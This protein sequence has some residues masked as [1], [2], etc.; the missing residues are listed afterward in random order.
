VTLALKDSKV[1]LEQ[2][3]DQTATLSTKQ[4]DG[5]SMHWSGIVTEACQ[6]GCDEVYDFYQLVLEPRLVRLRSWRWSD[7]YLNARLDDMIVQL[8]KQID[9]AQPYVP[10]ADYDYR[11]IPADLASTKREFVCQFEESCLDFLM[12]QLEH[13]GVYFWFE[14]NKDQESIVF[15]NSAE[16]QPQEAISAV[17]YPKGRINA[18]AREIAITRLNRRIG[19]HPKSVTLHASPVHGNT[20]ISLTST[21]ATS[22]PVNSLGEHHGYDD[23]FEHLDGTSDTSGAVL[24]EWR[25]QELLCQS[26]RVEGESRTPGIRAGY[27]LASFEY[28]PSGPSSDYYIVL[29]SHEGYQTLETSEKHDEPPYRGRFVALPRWQE[30]AQNKNPLQFRPPRA[31]PVPQVA[32]MVNGFVDTGTEGSPKRY[33]QTDDKGR[34][35]IRFCFTRKQYNGTFNSAWVRLATPYTGGASS[36]DLKPAGM[37]FPLREGTEVLIAFINGNPDR[38]VIV[39]ALPNVEAPSIVNSGNASEHLVQTP[40]GN[41]LALRDAAATDGSTAT[42]SDPSIQLSSPTQNSELNL[43][44]SP[45]GD[46]ANDGFSLTTDNHGLL[47]AGNSMLIE[48]P[49]HLHI[50]AGGGAYGS[51]LGSVAN[52]PAGVTVSTSGGIV[53]SNFVGANIASTGGLAMSHFIGAKVDITEA[54]TFESNISAGTKFQLG[55]VKEFFA[56][57]TTTFGEHTFIFGDTTMTGANWTGTFADKRETTATSITASG[58]YLLSSPEIMFSAETT[59]FNMTPAS[60]ILESTGAVDITGAVAATLMGE[61][62]KVSTIDETASMAAAAGEVLI[63]GTGLASVFSAAEV[64]IQGTDVSI[65]GALVTI[66]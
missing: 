56:S 21:H 10:D 52:T 43:G 12:R 17:Y 53:V 49:G 20:T 1:S 55:P 66:A 63:R 64:V 22:V 36:K 58:T 29:I 2:L 33:A 41:V 37:H 14:Q 60:A 32:R 13:Y 11:I 3:L 44:R 34:Y 40:A 31:T 50:A 46:S 7:I 26:L 25:D 42:S 5:T 8:L 24:A 38:P 16:Q 23:Q 9:M 6:Q 62:V 48:V 18:D 27:P 35:K 47:H 65:I 57:K 54:I 39:S 4:P 45:D 15:A 59:A 30:P 28:V 51:F 61:A 19:L